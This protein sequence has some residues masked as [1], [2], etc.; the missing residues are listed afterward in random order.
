LWKW[1]EKSEPNATTS[2]RVVGKKK[3]QK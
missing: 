1:K 3:E 2:P